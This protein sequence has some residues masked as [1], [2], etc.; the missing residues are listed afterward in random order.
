MQ[1]LY[2]NH[3]CNNNRSPWGKFGMVQAILPFGIGKCQSFRYFRRRLFLH[4]GFVTQCSYRGINLGVSTPG[5][6]T[7]TYSIAAAVVAP[8]FHNGNLSIIKP[9]RW[10]G[11]TNTS[12]NTAS[13]WQCNLMPDV[14]TD[15]DYS[16][17]IN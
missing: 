16:G 5:S 13:N 3:H 1:C 4:S 14:T 12:W 6:Y 2:Y 15:V 9:G 17:G 10:T 8:F 7:V 11:A